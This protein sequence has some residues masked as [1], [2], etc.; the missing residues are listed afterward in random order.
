MK[1]SDQAGKGDTYRSVNQKRYGT[2]YDRIF[3]KKGQNGGTK[4]NKA[5]KT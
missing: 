3:G 4:R 2:N 1:M 5:G